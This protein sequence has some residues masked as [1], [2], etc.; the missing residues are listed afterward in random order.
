M[1]RRAVA[2]C[3]A[4]AAKGYGPRSFELSGLNLDPSHVAPK[5]RWLAENQADIYARS[6]WF[7]L[8]CSYV[9]FVLTGE[10]AVDYANASSALLMDVRS[11]DWSAELCAAF[12]VPVERLAP[13]KPSNAILGGLKADIAAKLGLTPGLPVTV[14]TGDEHA[15]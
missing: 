8:P 11:R 13:I 6:R 10:V 9:G 5:I 12:D 4:V 7:L 3:D 15:A 14:G 2:Q 1:D